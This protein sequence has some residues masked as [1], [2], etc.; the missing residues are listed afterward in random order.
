MG[1]DRAGYRL[2]HFREGQIVANKID[3]RFLGIGIAL[4]AGIGVATGNLAIGIALGI[5]FGLVIGRLKA[6]K[7]D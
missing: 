1:E 4:G 3:N 7:P 5:V 2:K 6:R